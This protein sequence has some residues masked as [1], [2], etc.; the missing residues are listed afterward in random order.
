[1]K[2]TQ[3]EADSGID[4]ERY[5]TYPPR[6]AVDTYVGLQLQWHNVSS[7]PLGPVQQSMD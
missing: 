7:P 3:M 6:T 2:A 4:R 1:M 5:M